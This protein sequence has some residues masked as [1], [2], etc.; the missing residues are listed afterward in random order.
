MRLIYI[1]NIRLPTEK[2][3]GYQIMRTCAEL[4]RQGV[5]VE[6]VVPKRRNPS[7]GHV[8]P[9]TYYGVSPQF[10]V[11]RLPTLDVTGRWQR[12]IGPVGFWIQSAT[13]AWSV[14]R[15]LK[16]VAADWVYGRDELT[17]AL[18]RPLR[19]RIVLELHA[20]PQSKYRG[21]LSRVAAI[22]VIS[23]GIR[24]ALL[25][26]GIP[27]KKI[28]VAPDA[29]DLTA[30]A[31]LPS[32]ATCR[33][34]VGLPADKKIALYVGHLYSWKGVFTLAE[35]ARPLSSEWL[36]VFVGGMAEDAERL[37]QFVASRQSAQGGSAS[38]G[39]ANVHVV[40][41]QPRD[42][43]PAWLGAADVL[44]IPNSAQTDRS[45]LYTSPLKL[46]EYL[47]AGR[48]IVASDLPSIREIVSER[49]VI[50]VKPDDPHDLAR[51]I[52][53]AGESDQSSR[54]AAALQLAERYTWEARGR[55]IIEHLAASWA[56]KHTSL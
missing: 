52:R 27:E 34:T 32:A 24:D 39:W 51:G 23:H 25:A 22:V 14:R 12:W 7:L 55:Q 11:R 29:V 8:D 18:V 36:V 45:R 48:P 16:T 6:L 46:F 56:K 1:A 4:V 53:Q 19:Q 3:H 21:L 37:K 26:Q 15:Y 35:A 28:I 13:F 50:F 2:A 31:H 40:P 44:V 42:R 20:L 30:F 10:P 38:G 5:D 47:A 49:E 43:V 33:Q 9:Y 17:L 41:H 54:V